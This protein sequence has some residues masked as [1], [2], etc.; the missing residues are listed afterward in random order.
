MTDKK[1]RSIKE[2]ATDRPVWFAY[3][4]R[5]FENDVKVRELTN[6]QVGLYWH[7]LNYA[8]E[9]DV[10]GIIPADRE[11]L[12]SI[13]KCKNLE[14]FDRDIEPVLKC[15][16]SAT[17]AQQ[18][19][20]A[21]AQQKSLIKQEILIQKRMRIEYEKS[22]K[23]LSARK[24]G[25]E[26]SHERLRQKRLKIKEKAIILAEQKSRTLAQQPCSAKNKK[27]GSLSPSHSPSLS[28]LHTIQ[29]VLNLNSEED[30]KKAIKD[31]SNFQE[32]SKPTSVD[33]R[34]AARFEKS[35]G[36]LE[37]L[38]AFAVE[39][40]MPSSDGE[41]LFHRW[42]GNGWFNSGQPIKD[43]KATMRSWK[44]YGYMPSQKQAR[45]NGNQMMTFAQKSIAN[46]VAAMEAFAKSGKE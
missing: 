5:D 34:K 21:S 40:G 14:E 39:I 41:A 23:L 35:R 26:K 15:F 31:S 4:P 19:C 2:M 12:F 38:S 22:F 44:L 7:L 6:S 3:Y 46:T 24:K 13:S 37:E 9:S 36:T 18:P 16:C 27:N 32:T 42:Q 30:K 43:W 8:W 11:F 33:R 17:L 45:N 10:P 28:Y 25:A 29:S 20:S 1:E